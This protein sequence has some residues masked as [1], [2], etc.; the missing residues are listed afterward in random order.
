M[1][2]KL[3]IVIPAYKIQFICETF[4]SIQAQ[5]NKRFNL[6]VFDD[7]SPYDIKGVFE[8]Y[9]KYWENAF[10]HRFNENIGKI[11]L[12]AHWNRCV[13]DV[14]NEFV[15]LFSDDDMMTP[16]CVD[17]FYCAISNHRKCIKDVLRFNW[18]IIDEKGSCVNTCPK[19]KQDMTA[20]EFFSQLYYM[21]SIDARLQEFIFRSEKLREIGGFLSFDLGWRS[22]N[23][24]VISMTYPN[25]IYTISGEGMVLWRLSTINISGVYN[26]ECIIRKNNATMEFFNWIENFY[27]T[28][29]ITYDFS[30]NDLFYMYATHL[31]PINGHLPWL[32]ILELSFKSIAVNSM[33]NWFI[34]IYIFHVFKKRNKC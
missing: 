34:Y 17:D 14:K 16:T 1:K 26:R 30:T 12:V 3:G 4:Q 13:K 22:D 28:N 21:R 31:I 8:K 19:Y 6:Y 18:G 25:N 5:T 7:C 2:Y 11:N 9:F 24:T 33:I 10:Y 29:D 23:A 20:T 15:W 27:K 32:H